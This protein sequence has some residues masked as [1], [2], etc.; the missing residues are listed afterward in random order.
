MGGDCS[1]VDGSRGLWKAYEPGK[2]LLVLMLDRRHHLQGV[3]GFVTEEQW[4]TE[5]G[6]IG[7]SSRTFL[8]GN[9]KALRLS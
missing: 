7:L 4:R 2:D 5:E 6:L 9:E 8:R 1:A 3:C